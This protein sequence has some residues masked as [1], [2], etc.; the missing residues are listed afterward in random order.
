ML[1]GGR[2]ENAPNLT[3]Q[4][5]PRRFRLH[6]LLV[7]ENAEADPDT[8]PDCLSVRPTAGRIPRVFCGPGH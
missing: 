1:N 3:D 8:E 6:L 5:L 2:R 7:R 4:G